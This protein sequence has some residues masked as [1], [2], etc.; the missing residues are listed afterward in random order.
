MMENLE[1]IAAVVT[2]LVIVTTI[3]VMAY[4]YDCDMKNKDKD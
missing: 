1:V 4:R 2:L 3:G